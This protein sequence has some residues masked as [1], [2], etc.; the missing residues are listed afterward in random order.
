MSEKYWYQKP[1]RILQTVMREKDIIDYNASEVVAYMKRTDTNCI[2][3]N[4]GGVIDFF[5]NKHPMR[6]LNRFIGDQD[7]L[8]DLVKEC[9]AN[10]IRVIV[11]V[12][13]RGVE[14]ERYERRPDW[15][16]QNPDGT[17]LLGWND[18]IHRPCYT[19]KYGNDYAE[20]IL[21]YLLET[22]DIDGIWENC[23]IF[24]YGAC[25]CQSCRKQYREDTGK[26][27]PTGADYLSDGFA[28]YRKW[29]EKYAKGHME[30]M[31]N[32]IK[33][34]GEDK[35]YVSEIFSMFHA[36]IA[37]TSGIDLYDAKDC[38]DFLVSPYFLDGSAQPEMKYDQLTNAS[39]CIRFLKSI[40]PEKQCVVLTG[41]NGT[42]WRY[43]MA[44]KQENR[45]WYWEVA[46]VAGGLW[47]NYFNGQHPGNAVDR[48]NAELQK[49]VYEYLKKNEAYLEGQVPKEEVGIFYS[50]ASRDALGKNEEAKDEYGVFIKGT[51]RVLNESHIPYSFIP[52]LDF[53][54]NR[55]K[56][57]KALVIP[58]AAYMS[59]VEI[60]VIKEYVALGGG[61]V[62]T[63][64]TSLYDE[65]GNRRTDFGLK[66]LF[67]CSYT[68]ITKDTSF[69]C[70]QK[71][72]QIHPVLK[73]MQIEETDMIMNEGKTLI[74]NQSNEE[75]TRVCTYIPM[76]YNQPPEYAWI[77]EEK[78]EYPTIMAGSYGKGRV[79]YFANQTD[80][81][82][83]TNGHE[84]FIKTY[85]NAIEWVKR[86]EFLIQT[87]APE[88]VHIAV[89]Q[90][91]DNPGHLVLAFVNHT[92]A[93]FR[94]IRSVQ[95]VYNIKV[96]LTNVDLENYQI[97][98]AEDNVT[99]DYET[100]NDKSNVVVILDC[101]KEFTSIYLEIRMN[102]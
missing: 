25:Y 2:V 32:V 23:V 49:D 57:L 85:F 16:G 13:F 67:G 27:I 69:D 15:F 35:A 37:V 24:G 72:H 58:N 78:T 101:L 41:N 11:R 74:C 31:R 42:K 34:F 30:R 64:Q 20:E 38:F 59:D 33:S 3:V 70:Y 95:P 51:E 47:N 39:S 4:G 12:D 66:D 65:M 62:A 10:G 100:L 89:T 76:I 73:D 84:D 54:L 17:P 86:E 92:G 45:L 29:K 55:I 60:E 94:P 43:V 71:V 97:L 48:R 53:N 8:A 21:R 80:K 83:Y 61:L 68:G 7:I 91:K 88:S 56:H 46:S 81:C 79:V 36:S 82:C 87:D 1:I 90:D 14:Q 99:V 96:T 19:G 5:P 26:E 50:K 6:R 9:H 18:L 102:K 98:H 63:Y 52:N 75:Y 77:P 28:Q 93:Q 44:P 22:Y 40:S